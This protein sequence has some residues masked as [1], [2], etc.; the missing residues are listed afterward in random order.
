MPVMIKMIKEGIAILLNFLPTFIITCNLS[1]VEYDIVFRIGASTAPI[2]KE[3]PT[4]I[5]AEVR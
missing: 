2:N 1:S 3:P 4:Q 5:D